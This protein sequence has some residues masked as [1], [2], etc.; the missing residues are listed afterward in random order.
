[1]KAPGISPFWA[2]ARLLALENPAQQQHQA[3]AG[4]I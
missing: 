1:M 3:R 2:P 4:V